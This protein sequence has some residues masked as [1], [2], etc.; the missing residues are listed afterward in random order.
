MRSLLKAI[1][2]LML[3]VA[4]VGC[5]GVAFAIAGGY[6]VASGAVSP[7]QPMYLDE[8]APSSQA[9]IYQ[10]LVGVALIA[11]SLISRAAIRRKLSANAA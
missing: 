1:S 10:L 3:L 5:V 11:L 9:V 6:M 8:L 4:F 7:G 2:L